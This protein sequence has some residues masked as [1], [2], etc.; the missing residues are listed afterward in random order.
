MQ[1]PMQPKLNKGTVSFVEYQKCCLPT[2]T[3]T[4]NQLP[5]KSVNPQCPTTRIPNNK[6]IRP[7]SDVN[8][9]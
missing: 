3:V 1:M 2:S 4:H 7:G 8:A 5:F 9:K 6:H